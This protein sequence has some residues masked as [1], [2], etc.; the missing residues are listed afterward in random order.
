ME[1]IHETISKMRNRNVAQL[2]TDLG[3]QPPMVV[4]S[5]KRQ[6]TRFATDIIQEMDKSCTED[7]SSFGDH[8]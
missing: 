8:R 4:R 5:I 7:T 6:F 1:E 2:L 3:D